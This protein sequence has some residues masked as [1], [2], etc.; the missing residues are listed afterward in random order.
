MKGK[1]YMCLS[2]AEQNNDLNQGKD[3]RLPSRRKRERFVNRY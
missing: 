1:V 3:K 2:F